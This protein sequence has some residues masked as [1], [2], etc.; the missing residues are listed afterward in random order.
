VERPHHWPGVHCARALCHGAELC[1]TW[2]DRSAQYEAR[3]RGESRSSADFGMTERVVF[4]PLPCWASLE[5]AVYQERLV[6]LVR[7]AVEASRRQRAGRPVLGRKAILSQHPHEQ[8]ITHDRSPAPTVH[9]ATK[10]IRIMLRTA[11]WQFVV[12]FREAA[13]RLRSG[14]RLVRFPVGAFPPPLPCLTRSD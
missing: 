13:Q 11:Y 5:P 14:D 10:A 12:A 3:R 8:P 6:D 2:F 1:G 4:S 7:A 9:A